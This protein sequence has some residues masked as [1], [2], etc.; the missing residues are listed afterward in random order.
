MARSLSPLSNFASGERAVRRL[1][2]E[3]RDP[4][5]QVELLAIVEPLTPGKVAVFVSTQEAQSHSRAAALR[6]LEPLQAML[7]DAGVPYRSAVAFGSMRTILRRTRERTDI[8]RVLLGARAHD[9]L[10]R[11]RRRFVAHLMERPIVSVT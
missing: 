6:W 11:L 1:L 4:R 10:R 8:D 2:L 5:L 7:K 3:P 9:P